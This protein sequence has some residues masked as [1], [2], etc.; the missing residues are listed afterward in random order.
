MTDLEGKVV[1][2]T[3]AISGIGLATAVKLATLGSRSIGTVR[4]ETKAAAVMA[5]AKVAGVRVETALL[6]VTDAMRC[7]E[8]VNPVRP[9]QL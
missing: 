5:A 4:S 1:L 6:D 8:V 7:A 2:T 3:G 9:G